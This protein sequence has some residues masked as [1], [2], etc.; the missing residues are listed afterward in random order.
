MGIGY[1]Y[2]NYFILFKWKWRYTMNNMLNSRVFFIYLEFFPFVV[3]YKLYGR[4]MIFFF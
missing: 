2:F 3:Y 4:F 1:E